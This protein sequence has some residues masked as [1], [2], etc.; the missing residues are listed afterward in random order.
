VALAAGV[1]AAVLGMALLA[2]GARWGMPA[3]L[4]GPVGEGGWTA[5]ERAWFMPQG[6]SP[7][8]LE[9]ATGRS[10]SWSGRTARLI[11]PS[12]DRSQPHRLALQVVASRPAG[13]PP[14][15]LLQV[16]VDGV[17]AGSFQTS[18]ER[19]RVSVDLPPRRAPG[20][21]VALEV[22]NTFVPS[23]DDRRSLGVVIDAVDLQPATGSFRVAW[24]VLGQAGLAVGLLALGVLLFGLRSWLGVAMCVGIAAAAT[25]LL[26]HD[27]AF[28]GVYADRL[29]RIGGGV[30]ILGVLAAVVR[31]RWPIVAGLPEFWAAAGLVLGASAVK[32]AYLVHPLV[33]VGDAIFQ[34][35]RA[36]LVHAGSYLF[37]SITP[38]PFFE[39]PYPIALYVAALPF[40]TWFPS[41]AELVRLLRGLT[42]G[43]DAL[44]GLAIYAAARRQWNDRATA[45]LCAALWPFARAPFQGLCNANLTN[46]FGQG[47]FGLAI[48]LIV[49]AAAGAR[50]SAAG[51]RISATGLT[52]GGLCLTVGFLS[53]F[54]TLSV[55]LPILA[56]G[57]VTL[58]ALGH[59]AVRRL[60]VWVIVVTLAA[61]AT[62]Y[63][64]YY[65]HFTGVFRTTIARVSTTER[66]ETGRSIAA[67]PAIKARLWIAG[68]TNDYGL[69]GWPLLA[70][71]CAGAALLIRR[72]GR[73]ALTLVLAGWALVWMG[74]SALGILTTVE[75]R[76][77]LATAPVF[78]CL[79]AYALGA[80]ASK[81]G[82]GT[83]LASAAT[84]IIVWDAV[85]A[86][87]RCL[88]HA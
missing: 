4:S 38:R 77:S 15:P 12:L 25:W 35:H 78:V 52:L 30:A 3:T 74:F 75:M 18:N 49:W 83:L 88:G 1:A 73:D 5:R 7:A 71:A 70:A 56:A 69:P 6:F 44:V 80:L 8:E 24:Q 87:L 9:P 51:A 29:V 40:W 34:V 41:E 46:V 42:L 19:Q 16:F 62:A 57:A 76:A 2:A 32:L 20:A 43:A 64:V 68:A 14:P 53:H 47:F 65:R 13:A 48:G 59:G 27:G 31:A 55:G 58:A 10:F 28:I 37:T 26:L 86:W 21:L 33:T 84:L 22:S 66:V 17:P 23:P 36:Q 72:R 45:L 63:V 61:S 85:S 79:G 11:V 67:S 54:S 82:P 50:T 81:P 60:G 39:F